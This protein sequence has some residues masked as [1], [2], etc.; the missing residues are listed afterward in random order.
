MNWNE[1]VEKV[2]PHVVKIETTHGYGTGFLCGYTSAKRGAQFCLITTAG[3]VVSRANKW[4]GP[5]RIHHSVSG[6]ISF[7]SNAKRT[8][9]IDEKKDSAVLLIDTSDLGKIKMPKEPIKL[10]PIEKSLKIGVEVGW[11]GFPAITEKTLCF[12]SGSVSAI[13]EKRG[14]YLIDGVAIP[15]VSGGP[16]LY[17]DP[18]EG[19][20]IV[21]FIT[22]YWAKKEQLGLS[23]AQDVSHSHSIAEVIKRIEARRKEE[24]SEKSQDKA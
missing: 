2:T 10:R 15:G 13:Q 3:H 5:I 18:T 21:G 22:A 23:V 8:A 12:F 14:A 1:V 16:V 20:Q 9:I 19:V 4:R 11:L 7:L 24:K 6:E 17:A